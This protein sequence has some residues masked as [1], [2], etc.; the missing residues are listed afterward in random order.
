MLLMTL[1]PGYKTTAAAAYNC[2]S[3]VM[4]NVQDAT[5]F[6]DSIVPYLNFQTSLAYLKDPPPSYQKPAVDVLGEIQSVR[7]NLTSGGF[8]RQYDF[9]VALQRIISSMPSIP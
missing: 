9:D 5:Q 3:S 8:L 1:G 4:I 6:L 7:N 2:I